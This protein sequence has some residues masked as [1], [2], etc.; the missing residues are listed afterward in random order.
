LSEEKIKSIESYFSSVFPFVNGKWYIFSPDLF[1]FF[2]ASTLLVLKNLFYAKRQ[3]RLRKKH[4]SALFKVRKKLGEKRLQI[5]KLQNQNTKMQFQL[6]EQAGLIKAQTDSLA[7]TCHELRNPLSSI[8]GFAEVISQTS[9]Q[10]DNVNQHASIIFRNCVH[11]LG[12]LDEILDFS[13][14]E[15]GK[16]DT[17]IIETDLIQLVSDILK[18]F[19]SRVAEKNLSLNLHTDSG[20]PRFI[21]TDSKKLRQILINLIGNAIKFTNDGLISLHIMAISI[22]PEPKEIENFFPQNGVLNQNFYRVFFEVNDTGLGLESSQ[23]KGLFSAFYQAEKSISRKFGG[24]GLGIF[25]SKKLSQM[26]GGDLGLSKSKVGIGSSFAFHILASSS[27]SNNHENSNFSSPISNQNFEMAKNKLNANEVQKNFFKVPCKK[28]LVA[29]DAPDGLLLIK[30]FLKETQ[31]QIITASNGQEALNYVLK[32]NVDFILI[33]LQMP[34]MDGKT[35]VKHIRELG[36]LMPIFALTAS[37][38]HEEKDY[39]LA[40]GFNG[41]LVKPVRKDELMNCLQEV[42]S[43]NLSPECLPQAVTFSSQQ[44]M[45]FD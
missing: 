31:A 15:A 20:L 21:Y 26:L 37:A 16:I 22:S 40:H 1:F 23:M 45:V 17:E 43:L 7:E 35:A 9:T 36:F 30:A 25:L 10:K 32:N 12:L 24:T 42:F 39:C 33:D 19:E 13:K 14:L 28:I 41:Y 5:C 11:L 4:L 34:E 3:G 2:S 38:Q 6:E 27:S 18:L 29:D 44:N 8:M